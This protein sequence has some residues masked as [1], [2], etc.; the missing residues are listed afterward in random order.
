MPVKQG[1]GVHPKLP[2][3]IDPQMFMMVPSKEFRNDPV[4]SPNDPDEETGPEEGRLTGGLKV[5]ERSRGK[6]PEAAQA[7]GRVPRPRVGQAYPSPAF[8]Q[9]ADS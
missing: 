1:V 2:L 7:R 8:V 9:A 5:G 3:L 4:Q 6:H